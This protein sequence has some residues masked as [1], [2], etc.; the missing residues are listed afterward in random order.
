MVLQQPIGK[1]DKYTVYE[2]ILIMSEHQSTNLVSP[3]VFNLRM[4]SL[5]K[6]GNLEIFWYIS[7]WG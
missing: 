4:E 3:V 1:F 6:V 7:E 5:T 2:Y